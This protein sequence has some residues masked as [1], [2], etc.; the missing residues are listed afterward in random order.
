MRRSCVLTVYGLRRWPVDCERT[1]V[2]SARFGPVLRGCRLRG[3]VVSGRLR[4][5][6]RE[7]WLA[8]LRNTSFARCMFWPCRLPVMSCATGVLV[9]I[10]VGHI[11]V[12]CFQLGPEHA[13]TFCGGAIRVCIWHLFFGQLGFDL[14]MLM[15]RFHGNFVFYRFLFHA[16]V[17]R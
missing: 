11:C 2:L 3:C 5:Q 4:L 17:L 7:P 15:N 8:W 9:Y 1:V 13:V 14:I 16:V 10:L 6:I 12:V